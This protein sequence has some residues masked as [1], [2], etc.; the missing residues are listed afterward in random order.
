MRRAAGLRPAWNK[1]EESDTNDGENTGPVEAGI[2]SGTAE[3]DRTPADGSWIGRG[4]ATRAV[5]R[6]VAGEDAVGAD[7]GGRRSSA[8]ATRDVNTT[9]R[10]TS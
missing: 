3:I 1:S 6:V 8:R 10:V 2:G 9:R 7:G 5:S 4:R